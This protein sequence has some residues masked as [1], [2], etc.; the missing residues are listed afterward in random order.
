MGRTLASVT[1]QV[2]LE[3]ER[4][5]RFRRALPRE[6]QILFDQ[7]FAFARKRIAAT[8]MAAD[9]LPMQSILMSM[10]IG[11]L[12]ICLRLAER[13]D[14]AEEF[15]S[16]FAAEEEG[17]QPSPSPSRGLKRGGLLPEA[18]RSKPKEEG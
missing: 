6:D 14:Q 5:Q 8:A 18:D 2:Q 3:E 10:L 17:L 7:L 9:P 12:G 11:V 13:V 16:L 1:Q 15:L 4:L